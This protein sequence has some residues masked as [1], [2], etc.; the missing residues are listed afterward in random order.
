MC[1]EAPVFLGQVFC[2]VKLKI[3]LDTLHI[4]VRSLVFITL[5]LANSNIAIYA[6]GIAQL[7]S[8]LTIII[9]NYLFFHT[10]INKLKN[11]RLDVSKKHLD[12]EQILTKYGSY[13]EN[14]DDFPFNNI[15]EMIPGGLPN[16]G[17][18]FNSDLQVLIFSFAKQGILKQ[19]LTEGEKYVMS[20]SPWL[21]FS[22]QATYDIVNNMGSLAARFIFRPIE[23]SSY[24]YFT[25]TIARDV[26]LEKQNR[27]CLLA[28]YELVFMLVF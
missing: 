5:V 6:F 25:Q 1:A 20:V 2:F 16:S 22:E 12:N 17:N 4:M 7:S 19:V 3:V 13:Y 8:A 15:R 23:D 9:G 14:M 18:Y 26:E 21:S 10:Y 28:Y 24:F 27:V 11:Y